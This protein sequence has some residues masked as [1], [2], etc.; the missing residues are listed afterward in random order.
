[1]PVPSALR[2]QACR[3]HHAPPLD[4]EPRPRLREVPDVPPP[5]PLE[6]DN[7]I[8]ENYA[9]D[10]YVAFATLIEAG[11]TCSACH[12]THELNRVPRDD[13]LDLARFERVASTMRGAR[14]AVEIFT[15]GYMGAVSSFEARFAHVSA[16]ITVRG[17]ADPLDPI[18]MKQVGEE[19]AS[20]PVAR[21]AYRQLQAQ[22]TE[23]V[24]DFGEVAVGATEQGL[25]FRRKNRIVVF[26][27][28]HRSAKEAVATL[29]HESSH[30]H[31]HF[32]G[33]LSSQ[34]DEVRAFA[35]EFLYNE[36]RRPTLAERR[37]IWRRVLADYA[38]LPRDPR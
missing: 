16:K 27:R 21:R 10:G 32:R 6:F 8:A 7:Q 2:G 11:Y 37:D 22:G 17:A 29:V 20:N 4:P 28:L 15:A 13:E 1:M 33:G 18:L 14:V 12:L 3:V 26:M 5:E 36:G 19:I 23:V 24:L 31:R 25:A 35:R 34:V 38:D 30:M 9:V